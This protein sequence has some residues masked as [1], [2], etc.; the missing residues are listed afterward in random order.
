MFFCT[1]DLSPCAADLWTMSVTS[2]VKPVINIVCN[3]NDVIHVYLLYAACAGCVLV[4]F[5]YINICIYKS[6]GQCKYM[7]SWISLKM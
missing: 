7:H 3:K 1:L 5:Q 6:T 2:Q 4:K